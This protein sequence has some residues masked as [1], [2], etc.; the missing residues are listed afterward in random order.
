MMG[1]APSQPESVV[2]PCQFGNGPG[3]RESPRRSQSMS[4][5]WGLALEVHALAVELWPRRHRS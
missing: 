3:L 2:T 4:D 1:G 5:G